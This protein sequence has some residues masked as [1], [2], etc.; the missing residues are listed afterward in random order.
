[1]PGPTIVRG[2]AAFD[3]AVTALF[4]LPWTADRLIGILFLLD[5]RLFGGAELPVTLSALTLTF[6][7]IM[8]VLGVIWA[9]V[10]WTAPTLTYARMDAIG[11][12][13]VAAIILWHMQQDDLPRIYLLFV[14]TELLGTLVQL[15]LRP[16]HFPS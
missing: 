8:G 12:A 13:A 14:A 7:N 1:M 3:F 9:L 2:F 5:A 4:A 10:R 16:R 11:R 15:A 6:A